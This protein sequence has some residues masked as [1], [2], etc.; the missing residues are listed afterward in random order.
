MFAHLIKQSFKSIIT[1]WKFYVFNIASLVVCALTLLLAFNI[2]RSENEVNSSF[3]K[4][5]RTYRI[6]TKTIFEGSEQ[7]LATTLSLVGTQVLT[8]IPEVEEYTQFK[9]SPVKSILIEVDQ[10]KL[11]AS[12]V[13]VDSNFFQV[14]DFTGIRSSDVG[15]GR[16]ILSFNFSKRIAGSSAKDAAI[17]IDDEQYVVGNVVDPKGTDFQFDI[18]KDLVVQDDFE[19]VQ[20]YIV[21]NSSSESVATETERK[22]NE[23]AAESLEGQF[24][25]DAMKINFELESL[26]EIHFSKKLYDNKIP[27]SREVIFLLI[28]V[29]LMLFVLASLNHINLFGSVKSNSRGEMSV[30][31]A[32]GASKFQISQHFVIESTFIYLIA[33]AVSCILVLVFNIYSVLGLDEIS[34]SDFTSGTFVILLILFVTLGVGSGLFV[35]LLHYARIFN[36]GTNIKGGR[37]YKVL[38]VAQLALALTAICNQVV[39]SKQLDMIRN[40]DLGLRMD[41][42]LVLRSDIEL[43]T[44]VKNES[45]SVPEVKASSLCAFNS[46][47]GKT[48]EIQLFEKTLVQDAEGIPALLCFVDSSY[49][50]VLSIPATNSQLLKPKKAIISSAMKERMDVAQNDYLNLNQ[51]VGFAGNTVN[52]GFY[53]KADYQVYVYDSS[54]FDALILRYTGRQEAVMEFVTRIKNR[55]FKD[56]SLEAVYLP[57][58]YYNQYS[59]FYRISEIISIISIGILVIS[60]FGLYTTGRLLYKFNSREYSIRYFLGSTKLEFRKLHVKRLLWLVL[61]SAMIA[62]PSAIITNQLWLDEFVIKSTLSFV[63]LT[64]ITISFIFLSFVISLAILITTKVDPVTT[65]NSPNNA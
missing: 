62:I 24:D 30:R 55:N 44:A 18:Y 23:L 52:R 3:S 2:Y 12:I 26:S 31:R 4:S 42:V 58:L 14:F 28:V 45:A 41:N 17:E 59:Q 10:T 11:D 63:D 8:S 60:L 13:E 40:Y 16:I 21:L 64:I 47:P 46:L 48:P 61:I 32:Y 43:L 56:A 5:D 57:D 34:A 35:L 37:T 38:L 39:A 29:A 7:N 50:K 54:K 9:D 51:V 36:P 27:I 25:D 53:H 33:F 65:I 6:N 20:I 19:W 22:I 49:F 15:A 1:R